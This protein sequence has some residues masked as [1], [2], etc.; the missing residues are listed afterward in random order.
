[1][2]V[3]FKNIHIWPSYGKQMVHMPIIGHTLFG[4]IGLNFYVSS[5]VYHRW[6][7]MRN[8]SYDDYFL[9]WF[10][11]HFSRENV[12]DH[13]AHTLQFGAPNPTKKL[14]H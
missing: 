10:L 6:V 1:M 2:L 12:R 4:P 13:H 11:S 7:M 5:G 14:A 3:S 9:Y 8:P